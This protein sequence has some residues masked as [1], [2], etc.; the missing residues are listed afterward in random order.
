[1]RVSVH[2]LSPGDMIVDT[3][4]DSVN[5]FSRGVELIIGVSAHALGA[6]GCTHVDVVVLSEA[7][8]RRRRF[9]EQ[10]SVERLF[11]NG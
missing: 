9:S 8:I 2:N 4:W 11:H 5:G 3:G 7:G 6:Q 10:W 1:M